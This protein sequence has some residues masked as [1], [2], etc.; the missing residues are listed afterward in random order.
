MGFDFMPS[1]VDL[2]SQFMPFVMIPS[3][4]ANQPKPK[5]GEAE[6]APM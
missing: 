5:Q 6:E 1:L 4:P 2:E 3:A